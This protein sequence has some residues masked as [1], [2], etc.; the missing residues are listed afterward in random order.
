[1]HSKLRVFTTIII[2]LMSFFASFSQVQATTPLNGYVTLN[3]SRFSYLGTLSGA[4]AA[5][6][7]VFT[8]KS[9]GV[10]ADTDT[11]NLFPN[12]TV[13]LKNPVGDGCVNRANYSVAAINTSAI[14]RVG[15]TI[16][17]TLNDGDNVVSSQSARITVT[18]IPRT[19]IPANGKVVVTIQGNG[20][21][22]TNADGIPDVGGF[23]AGDITGANISTHVG[24]TS[25]FTYSGIGYTNS[26]GNHVV[27]LTTG[28]IGVG[29]TC[30]FTIGNAVTSAYRF[31]N[32]VPASG[33]TRGVSSSYSV[34]VE[35][36]DTAS[37]TLDEILLKV[38][39]NDGVIV[40][41]NVE[42]TLNYTIAGVAIGTTACNSPSSITTTATAVPFD[43]ITAYNVF[44][45]AAQSHMISTNANSG[46]T[47]TVQQDSSLTDSLGTGATIPETVCQASACTSTTPRTWTDALT[48]K[49]FGYSLQHKSGNTDETFTY[50]TGYKPL[51]TSPINILS[52]T[53]SSAQSEAYSCYRLAV[54][55]TQPIGYYFN[56]LTYVATPKF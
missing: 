36:Q 15:T 27:T 30:S 29:T 4:Y 28:A 20:S 48:Y 49:G 54:S 9:T 31:I 33:H 40:S 19:A 39:P 14:F 23:D 45:D 22:S 35:T 10:T 13:C 50:A 51:T 2:F 1:M 55:S 37:N 52:R 34:N 24:S 56:K 12:D 38:V 42:M 6:S 53:S 32:P 47:L 43:A 44:Y 41:A 11:D 46:Y 7:S 16:P 21:S 3:N 26:S 8:I 25:G 17:G 18:F 5:N